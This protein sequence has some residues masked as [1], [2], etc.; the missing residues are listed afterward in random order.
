ME[1]TMIHVCPNE[2]DYDFDTYTMIKRISAKA[3]D[4][5]NAAIVAA[6]IEAAK[7]AGITDLYLL[8][9]QFV[10]EAIKEKIERELMKEASHG[11]ESQAD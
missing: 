4:L 9:K 3:V 5:Q 11:Q 1:N 7:E 8:D 10:T 2:P 6:C